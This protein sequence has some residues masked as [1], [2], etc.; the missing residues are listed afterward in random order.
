M[1]T[2]NPSATTQNVTFDALDGV[3]LTGTLFTPDNAAHTALLINSGTG[4]PRRFY[5]HFARYAASKGFIVLTY[6]YR[7]IGDS[8]P[9]SLRGYEA[10]YRDW[11]QRD[12]PGGINFLRT[13]Y[14][15][16]PLAVIGHSTGGQQLGLANNVSEV[17]A[18]IFV[19]VS[20]GYWRGMPPPYKWLTLLLWKIYLPITSRLYG[21]A[22][23]RKIRWGENLPVGVAREWGNWCLEPEYLAAYF[24]D[25]GHRA[26]HDGT[27][28]GPIFYAETTCPIR[29]YCFTDDPIATPENIPPMLSL[30]NMASVEQQWIQPEDLEVPAIGHLGFFRRKIGYPLWGD[31]LFWLKTKA[32]AKGS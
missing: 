8:A 13:H 16:R 9:A 31:A 22:P 1:S 29:A 10:K 6:D 25:V 19:A 14:P 28:F 32:P 20:T 27:P 23:A 12:V 26:S 30:F 7:G 11:G 3:A 4:I 15:Q 5:T 18:A 24:D 21:Y 2:E 17:K